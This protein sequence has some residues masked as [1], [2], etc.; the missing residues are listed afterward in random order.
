M[1]FSGALLPQES[2]GDATIVSF[3]APEIPAATHVTKLDLSKLRE[4]YSNIVR[5]LRSDFDPVE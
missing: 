2:S 4:T 5:P 3:L 1:A